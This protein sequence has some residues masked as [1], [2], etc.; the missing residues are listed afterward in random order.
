LTAEDE[1][2]LAIDLMRRR[3]IDFLLKPIE[4]NKLSLAVS[5]AME[6]RRLLKE[7]E[8]YRRHVWSCSWLKKRQR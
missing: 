2:T 1:T 7:N 8:A 5:R 6:H 3:A 4:L